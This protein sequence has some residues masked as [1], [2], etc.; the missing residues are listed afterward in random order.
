MHPGATV[1]GIFDD[2]VSPWSDPTE[3]YHVTGFLD[4]GIKLESVWSSPSVLGAL[5]LGVGDERVRSLNEFGR[6]APWT[7]WVDGADSLGTA[8][9]RPGGGSSLRYDLGAGDV[10]RLQEGMARLVEMFFAAGARSVIPGIQGLQRGTTMWGLRRLF[11]A[12]ALCRRI[13]RPRPITCSV[14]RRWVPTRAGM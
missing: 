7:V 11:A 6:T 13:F 8:R 3:G 4:E 14:R 10:S 5:H 2:D 1:C 9:I 12:H